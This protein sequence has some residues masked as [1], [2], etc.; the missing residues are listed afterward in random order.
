M[1]E[2]Q[3]AHLLRQVDR[4]AARGRAERTA[5]AAEQV[6]A[7]RAV[8]GSA[9]ALLGMRLFTGAPD[10]GTVLHIVRAAAALGKLPDDA[11]LDQVG[12]RLKAKDVLVERNRARFLAVESGDFEVHHAPPSCAGA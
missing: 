7:H 8:T 5:A 9:G 12:A 6:P 2:R 1:L 3:R 10:L 11:A 4:V